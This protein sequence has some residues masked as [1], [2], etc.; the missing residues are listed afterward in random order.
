MKLFSNT[1]NHFNS[2][3]EKLIKIIL[4]AL[5]M[6]GLIT[7]QHLLT[8]NNIILV[9]AGA[10]GVFVGGVDIICNTK[11]Y[12][13]II[14]DIQC[15]SNLQLLYF[16]IILICSIGLIIFLKKQDHDTEQPIKSLRTTIA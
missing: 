3:K 16:L 4:S 1:C 14:K 6:V 9:G 7:I 15:L 2:N 5:I 13:N 11:F 12:S 10:I 8:D